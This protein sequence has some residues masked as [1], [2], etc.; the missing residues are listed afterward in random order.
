[1]RKVVI[2]GEQMAKCRK[3]QRIIRGICV[4]RNPD[5]ITLQDHAELWQVERGKKVPDR[6]S[7]AYKKMYETWVEWS[8]K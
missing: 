7:K 1:L 6:R 8:W 4:P 2:E 5:K 3:G